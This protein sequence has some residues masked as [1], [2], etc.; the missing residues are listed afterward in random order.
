MSKFMKLILIFMNTAKKT[1]NNNNNKKN[2]QKNRKKTKKKN[3]LMKMDAN[4][5]YLEL[6][7]IFPNIN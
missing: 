2:K 5:Y 1:K 3:K 7:F 4:I 6:M